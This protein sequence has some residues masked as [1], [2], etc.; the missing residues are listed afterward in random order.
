[1]VTKL[2]HYTHIFKTIKRNENIKYAHM[3]LKNSPQSNSCFALVGHNGTSTNVIYYTVP[4]SSFKFP[5][6][7]SLMIRLLWGG[8]AEY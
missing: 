4:S 1:M 6:N 8:V 2:E 3:M 5:E 7:T